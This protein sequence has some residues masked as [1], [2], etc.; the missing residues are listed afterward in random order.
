MT[1]QMYKEILCDYCGFAN[2]EQ[3]MI[4]IVDD[5]TINA[6]M[7]FGMIMLCEGIINLEAIK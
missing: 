4:G 3:C 2:S 7:D 1:G 6:C 5:K